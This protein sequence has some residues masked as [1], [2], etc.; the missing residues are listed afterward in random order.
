MICAP[1]VPS[2]F[3]T[4]VQYFKLSKEI[5]KFLITQLM[6]REHRSLFF[7]FNLTP[8][9]RGIEDDTVQ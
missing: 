2:S 1:I 9:A 4:V 3:K 7:L 8:W 6:E 5:I